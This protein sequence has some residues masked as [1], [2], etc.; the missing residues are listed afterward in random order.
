MA[1]QETEDRVLDGSQDIATNKYGN[2]IIVGVTGRIKAQ[3]IFVRPSSSGKVG[4]SIMYDGAKHSLPASLIGSPLLSTNE[5]TTMSANTDCMAVVGFIL[6]DHPNKFSAR[7]KG[8]KSTNTKIPSVISAESR[9]LRVVLQ[10]TNFIEDNAARFYV[11]CEPEDGLCRLRLTKLEH[12][13][14]FE[15][16]WRRVENFVS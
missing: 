7:H 9:M 2:K 1:S 12:V 3:R 13:F 11:A 4:C 16:V 8:V 14:L 5:E 15:E 10:C 6:A